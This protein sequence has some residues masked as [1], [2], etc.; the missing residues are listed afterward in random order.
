MKYSASQ[1]RDLYRQGRNITQWIREQ[2]QSAEN[3]ATAILYAYDMQ[4]GSYLR[5]L[6]DPAIRENRRQ[7]GAK[8]GALFDELGIASVLDAG[9]GEATSLVPILQSMRSKPEVLAFDLSLSRLLFARRHLGD[10]AKTA[11][12]FVGD[13][14]A[15]PLADN[16]IDCVFTVHAV[17]PNGGREQEILSELLRVAA[18]YLVM[19]EP[20]FELGSEATRQ[21]IMEHGYVRGLP[22]ILAALGHKPVRFERWGI[23]AN[24]RNEAA[25]I[26][27]EKK[28]APT[29]VFAS[30]IS[31]GPLI[32]RRDCWYCPDDGHAFPIIEGIPSLEVESAVLASHLGEFDVAD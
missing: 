16:S 30:P 4:A 7:V 20:S 12:L 11:E 13:L 8:L 17:E 2:E 29:K 19:V 18:R 10:H 9:T 28:G 27:V 32:R 21:R 1:L 5:A 24:P 14:A 6:D 3:S 15:I 31:G 23:D 26:I 25:L 22:D